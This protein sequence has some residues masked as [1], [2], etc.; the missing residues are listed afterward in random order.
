FFD[1]D[2]AERNFV[3]V[4]LQKNS[5]L[6]S[7][8]KVFP[9]LILAA[10]HKGMI[11]W[12]TALIFHDLKSVQPMLNA[13]VRIHDDASAIPFTYRL[14]RALIVDAGDQVVKGC[15][16]TVADRSLLGIGMFGIIE[17]LIFQSDR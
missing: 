1:L 17:N 7:H 16:R 12:R 10:G 15:Q 5:P 14:Q 6:L 2:T 11:D 13:V 3:A 4:I 8:T 9:F